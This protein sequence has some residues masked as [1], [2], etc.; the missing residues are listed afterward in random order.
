MRLKLELFFFLILLL[1]DVLASPLIR[2]TDRRT[3]EFQSSLFSPHEKRMDD[4]RTRRDRACGGGGR[5]TSSQAKRETRRCVPSR[6]KRHPRR[7]SRVAPA[8]RTNLYPFILSLPFPRP[9]SLQKPVA[10]PSLSLPAS[11]HSL[12]FCDSSSK[13]NPCSQVFHSRRREI[14]SRNSI[15]ARPIPPQSKE[16]G[17]NHH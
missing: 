2:M 4:E 13:K 9:S 12:T 6:P 3:V 11:N 10:P 5:E 1:P 17:T 16:G 15:R 8:G 14:A 7:R